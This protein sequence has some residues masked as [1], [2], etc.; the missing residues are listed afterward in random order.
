M[1]TEIGIVLPRVRIRDNLQLP[2]NTYVIKLRGIEVGR[3]E[4][5][6]T[7]FLAMNPGLAD[8][9]IEGAAATEPAFGLPAQWIEASTKDRAEM[10]GYTVVD[11][12][13]VVATHLTEVIR[14]HAPSVLSRQD[15]QNLLA[16]LKEDY[17]AVVEDLVP[18]VLTIGEI[19]QVLQNLLAERIPIRDLITILETLANH[20]GHT[21]D[22]ELL[23]EY[24]RAALARS[25][26]ALHTDAGDHKLHVITLSPAVEALLGEALRDTGD[27]LLLD[28]TVAQQILGNLSTQMDGIARGGPAAA[29]ALP[30]PPAPPL[31]PADGAGLARAVHLVVQ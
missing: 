19:Q 17:P 27:Q 9:P 4:L 6:M 5:Q 18:N 3:G 21:R 15:V 31:A 24:V 26:T 28:P 2:P 23:T 29:A 16:S 8:E 12:A 13:S 14:R 30:Q 7:K 22:P 10:L 1:A 25:I 20:A 11:P